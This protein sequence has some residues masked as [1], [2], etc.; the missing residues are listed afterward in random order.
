MLDT[1]TYVYSFFVKYLFKFFVYLTVKLPFLWVYGNFKI[2]SGYES[3]V[4]YDI[5]IANIF[6]HSVAWVSLFY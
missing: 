4:R 6:M 5:C 3:F 2:Y 1:F